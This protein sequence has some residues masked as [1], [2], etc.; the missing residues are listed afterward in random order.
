[1]AMTSPCPKCGEQISVSP[2]YLMRHYSECGKP[3]DAPPAPSCAWTQDEDM[4][5]W[6][7]ACGETYCFIEDGPKEN[8]YR[9]CPGCGKKIDPT[10]NDPKPGDPDYLG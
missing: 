6:N 2:G 10:Y 5:G 7:T 8:D 3:T 4:G 1:M 9:F